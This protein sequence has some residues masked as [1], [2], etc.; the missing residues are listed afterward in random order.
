MVEENKGIYTIPAFNMDVPDGGSY[1]GRTLLDVVGIRGKKG[2]FR[3]ISVEIPGWEPGQIVNLSASLLPEAVKG[4]L[5][6]GDMLLAR[7]NLGARKAKGLKPTNFEL[8]PPPIK[9]ED[10]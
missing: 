6:V 8:A 4:K 5:K 10:L 3:V 9:E 2:N 7:I 1:R